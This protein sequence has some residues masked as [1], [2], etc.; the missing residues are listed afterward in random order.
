MPRARQVLGAC[1]VSSTAGRYGCVLGARLELGACVPSAACSLLGRL[2][3][4]TCNVCIASGAKPELCA[5]V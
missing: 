4:G 1:A 2:A 3:K 5:I